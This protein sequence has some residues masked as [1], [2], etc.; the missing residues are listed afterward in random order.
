MYFL[1]LSDNK[2]YPVSLTVIKLMRCLRK[3][4][5]EWRYPECI[6]S[7]KKKI[8]FKKKMFRAQMF[9]VFPFVVSVVVE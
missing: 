4:G 5:G 8:Y 3:W 1:P 7:L 2:T 9:I 6:N